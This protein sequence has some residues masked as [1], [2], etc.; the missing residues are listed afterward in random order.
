L[1]QPHVVWVAHKY[2]LP[3]LTRWKEV[4][5]STSFQEPLRPSHRHVGQAVGVLRKIPKAR[6]FRYF[7]YRCDLTENRSQNY[8]LASS[9]EIVSRPRIRFSRKP[10]SWLTSIDHCQQKY[11]GITC[12]FFVD[13]SLIEMRP[14]DSLPCKAHFDSFWPPNRPFSRVAFFVYK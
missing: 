9:S 10:S 11:T 12:V 7:S 5:E 2:S 14:K 3:R 4:R 1:R 13:V 8:F 6:C